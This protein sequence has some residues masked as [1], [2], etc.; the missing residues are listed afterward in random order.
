MKKHY[1][2][3]VEDF[4]A[5]KDTDEKIYNSCSRTVAYF[6]FVNGYF[7]RFDKNGE[8]LFNVGIAARPKDYFVLEEEPEQEATEADINKLCKFW[9][10][11]E[12]AFRISILRSIER[13]SE[14]E[15]SF[16]TIS[17]DTW[18]HCRR[19]APA[20]IAELTGYKVSFADQRDAKVEESE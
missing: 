14:T 10:A 20:E 4:L 3:T 6:Q 8:F 7:C 11:D 12:N 17:D 19:L 2:R 13:E 16:K 1:L 9:D 18:L 15:Y 5:Y